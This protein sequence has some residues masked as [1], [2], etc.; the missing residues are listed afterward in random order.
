MLMEGDDAKTLH[1]A[2][3]HMA[4]T[5]QPGSPGN[6]ALSYSVDV[7]NASQGQVLTLVTCYRFYF[8]GAAPGR[9]I[10]RA[11]RL[12]AAQSGPGGLNL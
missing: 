4:G 9:F 3:G 11:E 1:R 12:S 7:L 2:A 10:V 5:P 8:V 6:V